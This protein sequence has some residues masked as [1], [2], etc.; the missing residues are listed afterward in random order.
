MPPRPAAQDDPVAAPSST[1]AGVRA[2]KATPTRLPQPEAKPYGPWKCTQGIALEWSSKLAL[3]TKPCQM[4]GKD[5]QY[6]AS[7]TAPGGTTGSITVALQDAG[8]GRTVAGP[9]TCADLAY[10]GNAETRTCGPSGA[11][12]A[13][14]H[15]Y[16]VVMSYRYV[17][18][19]QTLAGS[20]RGSAF[21]W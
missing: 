9:R 14:G 13:R 16:A 19:G 12:P 15:Q 21:A 10:G 5:I 8:S 2:R 6:Q 20:A 11:S 17:R 1:A 18:D 7:I 3:A 4:I